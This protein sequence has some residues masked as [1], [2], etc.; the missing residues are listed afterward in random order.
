MKRL[1]KFQNISLLL[2]ILIVFSI[3]I[4]VT[5]RLH[6]AA[7]LINFLLLAVIFRT[8]RSSIFKNII[9]ITSC[10]L[11]SLDIAL[12][13]YSWF[14][15]NSSFSDGFAISILDTNINECLS[16]AMAYIHFVFA[17]LILFFFMVFSFHKGK[18]NKK[19]SIVSCIVFLIFFIS[20]TLN[21]TSYIHE[22]HHD[23]SSKEMQ[24][25]SRISTYF[26]FFN[27]S[28]F[29]TALQNKNILEYYKDHIPHHH[30]DI[31]DTGIDTYVIVLGESARK[32]N[33]SI[34]GYNRE[35]TPNLEKYQSK[36][37][38]FNSAISGAPYTALAIPLA[39]SSDTIENHHLI[40]YSDNIINIANDAGIKTFWFSAQTA[41]GSNGTSVSAIARN[42]KEVIYQSTYDEDLIKLLN[43]SLLDPAK[44][45]LIVIHLNGSHEPACD[46]F[47]KD[48][49][50]FK[51]GDLF[52]DC[53]DNSIHYTDK[54][55]DEI[56]N[57]LKNKNASLLY[58]S[59]HALEYDPNKNPP[60][61][62]GGIKPTQEAYKV[63][64]FIW[65]SKDIF[66]QGLPDN[67]TE[68]YSTT[69]NYWLINSWLGIY[70]KNTPEMRTLNDVINEGSK[71]HSVMDS[72][73]S[74]FKF[75]KLKNK[76]N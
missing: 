59:D 2:V 1:F 32:E 31:H 76:L 18:S 44:K 15:F 3:N 69:Y 50:V 53:Y 37:I 25:L 38:S 28:Y 64:M 46:R 14:T 30:L 67:V 49:T 75:E 27:L 16:M 13:T 7:R 36:I 22:K 5:P 51:G 26:P 41:F 55:T 61:Y 12:S 54:I 20:N 60:Y 9:V 8:S 42:A 65:F 70:L 57:K 72:N 66:R 4:F 56:L 35:T 6:L 71:E 23:G 52:V 29:F 17:F 58:F 33:M 21:T 10:F 63:P 39:L 74:I 48:E 45:K 34:Y 11:M 19:I 43:K 47:P 62:H 73:G 68:N 40:N 24:F